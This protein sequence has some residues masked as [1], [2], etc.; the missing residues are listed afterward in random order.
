MLEVQLNPFPVLQTER[1]ILRQVLETDAPEILFLRSDDTVLQ[2]LD[3]DK[4]TSL[5]DIKQFIRSTAEAVIQNEGIMWGICQRGSTKVIGTIGHWRLIKE[6]YRSEIG[7]SLHPE[8]WQ[9]GIMSEAMNAVLA[10][11]FRQMKLH[12]VE[13]NVNPQ[14]RNSIKLLE[15]HGFVKEAHFKEN[16]YYNGKFLDS[17]IYSLLNPGK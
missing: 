1:L 8:F 11:G 15:K 2:Y 17:A 5:E 6:H 10:Y 7:Y 4:V 13:A 3:R 9:K 14:N 16:Y 12:S